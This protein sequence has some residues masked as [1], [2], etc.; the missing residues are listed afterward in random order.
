MTGVYTI[1]DEGSDARLMYQLEIPEEPQ[2]LQDQLNIGKT[3]DFSLQMKV[4]QSPSTVLPFPRSKACLCIL[5]KSLCVNVRHGVVHLPPGNCATLYERQTGN[6][7]K[8]EQ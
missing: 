7:L 3:G 8:L 6:V 5:H 1:A 2:E 4:C